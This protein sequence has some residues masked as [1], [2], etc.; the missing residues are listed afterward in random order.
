MSLL[1]CGVRDEETGLQMA[2]AVI[3]VMTF[4]SHIMFLTYFTF[5]FHTDDYTYS[6]AYPEE[7]IEYCL[8][9]LITARVLYVNKESPLLGL[10]FSA[11]D[12]KYFVAFNIDLYVLTNIQYSI[13]SK[14]TTT[15]RICL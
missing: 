2:D 14:N 5:I 4:K 3:N 1:F 12:G 8:S 13:I 6:Y 10:A 15:C 7:E 11:L 9:F